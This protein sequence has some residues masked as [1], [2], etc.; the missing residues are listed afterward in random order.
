MPLLT[1]GNTNWKFL[2]IVIVLALIVGGGSLTYQYW[3]TSKEE[4]MFS[5]FKSPENI[6][7]EKIKSLGEIYEISLEELN[8]GKNQIGLKIISLFK[9]NNF[10]FD[11]IN[12]KVQVEEEGCGKRSC[13][14][15]YKL[16]VINGEDAKEIAYWVNSAMDGFPESA[17]DRHYILGYDN[18][19]YIF[20]IEES[21]SCDIVMIRDIIHKGKNI[22][23]ISTIYK[24]AYLVCLPIN[25][26][27]K[28]N[29]LY[30]KANEASEEVR[31]GEEEVKSGIAKYYSLENG[32]LDEV[33]PF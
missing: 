18:F 22:N 7:Q 10:I 8:K 33:E 16:L 6:S 11:D 9:E 2:L 15:I 14:A 3:W 29:Q 17:H 13:Y 12:Y 31:L 20:S 5:E 23:Y 24:K 1:Q 25:I 28:N 30:I 26:I 19:L 27:E 21:P 4:T 32:S